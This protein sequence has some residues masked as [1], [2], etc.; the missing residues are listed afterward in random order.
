M[1]DA[2][3]PDMKTMLEILSGQP[4]TPDFYQRPDAQELVNKASNVLYGDIGANKDTRDWGAIMAAKDPYA[5]AREGLKN[6][7]SD[8]NYMRSNAD[9]LNGQG[10]N[11][12]A[13]DTTYKQMVDR[14]GSTYHPEWMN[15]LSDVKAPTPQAAPAGSQLA[16]SSTGASAGS[17]GN[18]G[19]IASNMNNGAT[20]SEMAA[21][22]GLTLPA[23]W[24]SY[25]PDQKIAW[26]NS[27][28]VGG[29]TLIKAGVGQTDIDWMRQHGYNAPDA[30]T[31]GGGQSTYTPPIKEG[32][33]IGTAAATRQTN[34]YALNMTG[35]VNQGNTMSLANSVTGN[36]NPGS[37][38]TGVNQQLTAPL[39]AT[40]KLP[41]GASV[42]TTGGLGYGTGNASTMPGVDYWH[43]TKT[44]ETRVAAPGTF[45]APNADWIKT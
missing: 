10:Y 23:G 12:A 3:K 5:A 34:P 36:S 4:L 21:R 6:M 43:N 27:N 33:L 28:N 45:V 14:V 32:S 38:I 44:G 29:N 19:L 42:K 2:A 39:A 18:T 40:A 13:A 17:A 30:V 8:V 7:Y 41:T 16:G 22:V 24:D 15:G 11:L 35:L 25:S 20:S 37:S 31:G 26:Y 1:A 9:A